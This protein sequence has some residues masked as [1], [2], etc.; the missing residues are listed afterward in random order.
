MS[1]KCSKCGTSPWR[2]DS[3]YC[4]RCGHPLVDEANAEG[5]KTVVASGWSD[6]P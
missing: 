1:T 5:R 4:I 6:R 3:R 2:A